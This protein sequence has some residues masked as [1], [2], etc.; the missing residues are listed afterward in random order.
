[1]SKLSYM[2]K[3][4][5]GVEVEWKALAKVAVT[6]IGEFVHK[7]KQNPSAKYPVYNGGTSPT[8]YYDKYNNTGKQIVVSAR[9]ANAGF[10]N[11]LY[12]PYWAGNSCYSISIKDATVLNWEFAFYFLKCSE[13]KLIGNQQKGG[14]PAVSKKQIEA[15]LIPIPP[16]DIQVEIV[17]ILDTFTELTA[18]LTAELTT[19]KKQYNHYRNQLITFEK[20]EVEW[21][22]LGDLCVIGDGLH[23]TPK[24]D[25]NG[26]YFFINGNNLD[27]GNIVFNDKTKKVNN[28]MFKRHGIIFTVEN[29]VFLSIN[30]T[31]G[32]VSFYNNEKI[33]LGKSIAFFNIKSSEL[34]SRYLFYFLQTDFSKKY[35]ESQKTGSTIKN[36]GLKALRSFEI[37][38]PTL[39]EQ[40]R[41]VAILDKFDALTNSITEGLPREIE[42]RQ[43]Q[44]EYYRERLL[45]FPKVKDEI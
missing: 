34:F 42:L 21:K 41:I 5:E 30:G 38:L 35:F 7:S 40:S 28:L 33:V 27:N 24:Y 26:E 12:K 6:T 22:T 1:M 16:L 43:K 9:G 10:V 4:L 13:N 36:L 18:E 39:A 31:I 11:R 3:L 15:F 44:Y 37:P 2:E 8:G 19:R 29:T 23:G 32:N 20:G 14:I 45:S 17:R 25:D